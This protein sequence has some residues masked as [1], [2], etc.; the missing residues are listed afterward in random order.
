VTPSADS[1]SVLLLPREVPLGGTRAMTVRRTLPHREIRTIGAWCFLDHYGPQDVSSGGVGGMQVPPHP[2]TGLQTVTWLL[3][4]H[5]VHDDSVGSHQDVRP[6]ELNLMTAGHGIAHSEVSA[7]GDSG[8][9]HGVQLWVALPEAARDQ[10]PHF[11]HHADL[12][13]LSDG[14]ARTTV[15]M[16]ELA[17]A[18]SAAATYSPLLA[19]VVELPGAGATTLPLE[20]GFEHAALSLDGPATVDATVLERG[21]LLALAPGR[22]A[23]TVTAE[24]PARVLLLG[25]A[26][27]EEDL[28]MWWNFVGR[29]HEE[30]A[31][32]RADWAAGERFGTVGGYPGDPLPAPALPTTRLL[33]RRSGGLLRARP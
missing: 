11:E 7:P 24:G 29:S 9:L 20:P 28:V 5:V 14:L 15:V 32:A 31:E 30:I 33:P 22:R 2:H 21:T 25:G 19:A 6:G 23:V 8:P 27:F 1:G 16:G 17:G 13:V 10:A 3:D 12:P 4:G 18:R 26:P